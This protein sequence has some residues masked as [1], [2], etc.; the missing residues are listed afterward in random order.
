MSNI[1]AI[2]ATVFMLFNGM[3]FFLFLGVTTLFQF[4]AIIDRI[5]SIF[6]MEE[7]AFTR[8]TKALAGDVGIDIA[9]ADFSWGF[10][11]QEN[12]QD[13]KGGRQLTQDDEKIIVG[14]I[15]FKLRA[16]DLL[17]VVGMVGSGKSTLLHSIME[18]TKKVKGSLSVRG[19]IAYVEQEPFI[20][21]SSIKENI[22]LGKR[23][24]EE[25]L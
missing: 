3:N 9:G 2:L 15:N 4:F 14:G 20:I 8:Q 21:S 13:A 5:A 25:M 24:N 17:V 16:K 18:E 6:D 1:V 11:V 23:M 10:R 22:L 7:N 19:T 12:Q